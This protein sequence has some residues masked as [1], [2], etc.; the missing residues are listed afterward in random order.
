MANNSLSFWIYK[1]FVFYLWQYRSF[2]TMLYLKIRHVFF[3][4]S[5]NIETTS[6][7]HKPRM[8]KIKIIIF[9]R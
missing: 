7:A 1:H 2:I 9:H 3:Q 4:N 6:M 8:Y 5:L